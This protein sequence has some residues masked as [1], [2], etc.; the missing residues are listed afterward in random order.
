MSTGCF[1]RQP[2]AY[3]IES[4]KR[5]AK[6]KGDRDA[7]IA[8]IGTSVNDSFAKQDA[9]QAAI[10]AENARPRFTLADVR[11][12]AQD[13]VIPVPGAPSLW[14]PVIEDVGPCQQLAVVAGT[15][16]ALAVFPEHYA[17]RNASGA[18]QV[19]ELDGGHVD[20][21]ALLMVGGKPVPL[22]LR[23]GKL[24]HAESGFDY[25][26]GLGLTQPITNLLANGAGTEVAIQLGG[27]IRFVSLAVDGS[28][29]IAAETV[30][31][32][33]LVAAVGDHA[34]LAKSGSPQE[35][36]Y[37]I[38][39]GH[40]ASPV[41]T[42]VVPERLRT[43]PPL[44]EPLPTAAPMLDAVVGP[45]VHLAVDLTAQTILAS[46]PSDDWRLG[47][48][49][50][51]SRG[52]KL[53]AFSRA[54]LLTT[55]PGTGAGEVRHL[56]ADSIPAGTT[57]VAKLGDGAIDPGKVRLVCGGPVGIYEASYVEPRAEQ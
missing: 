33:H 56:A 10:A 47:R 45:F 30:T 22:F 49:V 1:E 15:Q 37:T 8:A 26:D 32:A 4:A 48:R 19:S 28:A 54:L 38:I 5:D 41:I 44:T 9:A 39:Q 7:A 6:E 27:N 20:G 24:L 34:W 2:D 29:S 25:S 51:T 21:A 23:D 31:A 17:V 13:P 16:L 52:I 3:E 12:A 55:D 11:T 53:W 35:W 43:F 40:L 14:R 18:W 50:A 57:W 42:A 46:Y 36:T